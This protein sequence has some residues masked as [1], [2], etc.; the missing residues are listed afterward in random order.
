MKLGLNY[1]QKNIVDFFCE[2]AIFDSECVPQK[3]KYNMFKLTMFLQLQHILKHMY[4][5]GL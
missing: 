1:K 2:N 4:I 3:C 5:T